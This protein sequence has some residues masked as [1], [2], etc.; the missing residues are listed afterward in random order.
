MAKHFLHII[1]LIIFIGS[2][3]SGMK[4]TEVSNPVNADLKVYVT[5]IRSEADLIVYFVS[6]PGF[7]NAPGLWYLE[8]DVNLSDTTLY[9]VQ[10]RS[11]SD[12]VIYITNTKSEAGKSK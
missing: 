9:Y 6:D 7:S 2:H 3:V 12:L 1:L 5:A 8:S 11:S 4:V 10:D